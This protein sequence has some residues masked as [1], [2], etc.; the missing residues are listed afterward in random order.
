MFKILLDMPIPE[1]LESATE[2]I[3]T[4]ANRD[5]H[6]IWKVKYQAAR[7]TFRLFS[8][9]ANLKFMKKT[10]PDRAFQEYFNTTYAETLCESHL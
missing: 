3:D 7:I 4:I 2:D 6:I 5:K 8:R 9:Y 10:D 1:Q